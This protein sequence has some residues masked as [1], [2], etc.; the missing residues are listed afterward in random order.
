MDDGV[1]ADE[2]VNR[3]NIAKTEFI[4]KELRVLY[5]P[6]IVKLHPDHVIS[7]ELLLVVPDPQG[8]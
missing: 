1:S 6:K 8:N 2:G 7:V 5:L 4:V 3:F